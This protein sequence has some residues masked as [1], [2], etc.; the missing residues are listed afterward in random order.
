MHA[1]VR[2]PRLWPRAGQDVARNALLRSSQA[3]FDLQPAMRGGNGT[4]LSYR[5]SALWLSGACFAIVGGVLLFAILQQHRGSLGGNARL[6]HLQLSVR[7][8]E[9]RG[10]AVQTYAYVWK[11]PN[12]GFAES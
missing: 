7:H 2:A 3:S 10:T 11:D 8:P 4:E 9:L 5:K 1:G 6:E 12:D